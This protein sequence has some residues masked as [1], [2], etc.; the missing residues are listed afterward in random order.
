MKEVPVDGGILDLDAVVCV[1]VLDPD[2]IAK[3]VVDGKGALHVAKFSQHVN[4]VSGL[5]SIGCAKLCRRQR[6]LLLAQQRFDA[7]EMAGRG[8]LGE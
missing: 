2:D 3:D 1:S 6:K 4:E 5:D 8:G 7:P